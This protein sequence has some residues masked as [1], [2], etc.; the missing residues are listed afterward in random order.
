VG[1]VA[2]SP[3][4]PTGRRPVCNMLATRTWLSGGTRT[5]QDL[6]AALQAMVGRPIVDKTDLSGTFD[7]D[8]HW[9]PTNLHADDSVSSPAT[10]APHIFTALEEQLGLKLV[11]HKEPFRVL[12]VD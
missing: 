3:V 2:K 6:A 8:L 12:V 4:S 1:E 10:D 11:P 7:I 9:A 5:I